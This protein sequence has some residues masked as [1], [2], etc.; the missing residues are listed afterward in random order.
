MPLSSLNALFVLWICAFCF[1]FYRSCK[2]SWSLIPL[3]RIFGT[4]RVREVC[5]EDILLLSV[6]CQTVFLDEFDPTC[7]GSLY[8]TLWFSL[9]QIPFFL[10]LTTFGNIH[11]CMTLLFHGL[12]PLVRGIVHWPFDAEHSM[13]LTLEFSLVLDLLHLTS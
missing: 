3:M 13:N 10:P 4:K 11:A 1:I 7:F 6:W 12:R 2:F 8:S 5:L 9:I